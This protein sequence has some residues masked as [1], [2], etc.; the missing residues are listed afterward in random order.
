MKSIPPSPQSFDGPAKA[1]LFYFQLSMV[2]S[3][4]LVSK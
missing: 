3:D 1:G 2:L 4:F